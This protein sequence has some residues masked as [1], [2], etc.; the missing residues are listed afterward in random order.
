MEKMVCDIRKERDKPRPSSWSW[1]SQNIKGKEE[2]SSI[3]NH[4]YRK[5]DSME[6]T[7]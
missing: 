2:V 1:N 5:A 7:G 4:E 6:S 3:N